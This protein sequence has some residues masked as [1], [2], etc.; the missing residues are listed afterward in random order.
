[1][2]NADRFA[3]ISNEANRLEESI[4]SVSSEGKIRIISQIRNHLGSYPEIVFAYIHGSFIEESAFRDVD[5]AIYF[6]DSI[7]PR[8]QLQLCL[9]LAAEISH[10]VGVQ[11]DVHSLNTAPV[12]FRYHAT[13]GLILYS[14][15][16]ET[17][18]D[19]LEDTWMRYFDFQTSL[20]E[21]L[22]DLLS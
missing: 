13:R 15:D 1:M 7:S 16:E 2:D 6:T 21:S 18:C 8:D 4:H 20:E 17:R 10:L 9:T 5:I 19:F 12:E 22:A 14:R 11:A 3:R